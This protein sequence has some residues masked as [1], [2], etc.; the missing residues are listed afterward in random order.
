MEQELHALSHAYSSLEDDYQR[1]TQE[2]GVAEHLVP[3]RLQAQKKL[4]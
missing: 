1:Q 4:A 2:V 3:S